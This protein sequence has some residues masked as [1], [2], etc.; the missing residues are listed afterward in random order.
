MQQIG[1][2]TADFVK[3][4]KWYID[5]FGFDVKILEDDTV[6]ERMLPYTGGTAQKRHACIAVN[7]QGGSGLEIWQYSERTP[8]SAGFGIFTGDLGIFAAKIRCQDI[9]NFH[10]KLESKG[11]NCTEIKNDPAG[12]LCFYVTDPWDN[13]FQ[14]IENES[15]YINEKKDVGG[16]AGAMIGVSDINRSIKFYKE[17]LG[18]D[19]MPY[20][21]YGN[22][23]D[24]HELPGGNEKYERVLLSKSGKPSGPFSELLGSNEIEL[25]QALEHKPRRIYE[26]RW[27]GDPGF[28]Q[29]CY[30]VTGMKALGE[31]VASKGHP[32]TVDS[33]P[34]GERF[35]MGEASGHFTY[36]EDPDG[37]LIEFVETHRIPLAAK[38]G[39]Y[40]DIDRRDRDKALPRFLFRIM[41]LVSR[42]KFK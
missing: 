41:G 14:V 3:S 6:A 28:I 29:I 40:I 13:I 42:K 37:T 22:F 31:F 30:D 33:C 35:D 38:L 39:L 12:R 36:I 34:N 1:V 26:G 9:N 8:V 2:G 21:G 27:W 32:F 24:W 15:I 17:I 25:V 23:D 20:D 10:K 7:L 5:N 19:L 16:I 18:Y 4:W 11:V